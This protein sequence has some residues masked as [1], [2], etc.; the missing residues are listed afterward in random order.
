MRPVEFPRETIIYW[1]SSTSSARSSH[2]KG[3]SSNQ[4]SAVSQN[5]LAIRPDAADPMCGQCSIT[6][7]N[8]R[9][10]SNGILSYDL[11]RSRPIFSGL[12]R[13][14]A[15]AEDRSCPIRIT[16]GTLQTLVCI[17]ISTARRS[18]QWRLR[19]TCGQAD[20]RSIERHGSAVRYVW[21]FAPSLTA[22]RTTHLYYVVFICGF[23]A[24]VIRLPFHDQAT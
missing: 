10:N 8:I 13:L 3:K 5:R 18:R 1:N 16:S 4:R 17:S 11:R 15:Y 19:A 12:G 9:R 23:F 14:Q 21:D 24:P 20:A 2:A 7:N 6:K 22:P